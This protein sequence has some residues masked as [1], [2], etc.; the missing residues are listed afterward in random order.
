[1]QDRE[2]RARIEARLARVATGNFGDAKSVGGGVME[3]KMA[4]GP[5]YRVYFARIGQVVVLLLCG[6]DKHS[7]QKDIRRAQASFQDYKDRSR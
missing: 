6:G 1:M 5:G 4:W 2:E 7:Q 3:L